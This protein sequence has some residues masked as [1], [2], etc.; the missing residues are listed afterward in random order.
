MNDFIETDKFDRLNEDI[1]RAYYEAKNN[2]KFS[3]R[4]AGISATGTLTNLVAGGA[5]LVISREY[6]AMPAVFVYGAFAGIWGFLLQKN[7]TSVKKYS[8]DVKKLSKKLPIEI[9]GKVR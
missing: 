1:I 9:D 8:E 5:S 2:L 3:R 6:P 7:L 4:L